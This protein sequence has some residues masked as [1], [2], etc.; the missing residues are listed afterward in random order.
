MPYCAFLVIVVQQTVS[1]LMM[2]NFEHY[3]WPQV[4]QLRV[5]QYCLGV[6]AL[7][8]CNF[9]FATMAWHNYVYKAGVTATLLI[10]LIALK[11]I[12]IDFTLI[13]ASGL[14]LI[15]FFVLHNTTLQLLLRYYQQHRHHEYVK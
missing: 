7:I 15:L 8:F 6:G 9:I 10:L 11:V 1:Y 13:I 14:G 3:L 2:K 12:V 4:T 5:G